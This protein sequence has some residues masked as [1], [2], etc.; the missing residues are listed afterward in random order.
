[1]LKNQY[2]VTHNH[3]HQR[4]ESE[5]RGEAE[6]TIHQSEANQ[7][8][9]RH[10]SQGHHADGGDTISLEVEQQ[11]E[12]HNDLCIGDAL[13]DLWQGRRILSRRPPQYERPAVVQS[14]PASRGQSFFQ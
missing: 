13:K 12:E 1:M 2:L 5:D 7:R 11:E 6:G 4:D 10:Q 9:R 3:S 8:T 14:P